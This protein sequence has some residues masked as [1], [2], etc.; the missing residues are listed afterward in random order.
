[1]FLSSSFFMKVVS[2]VL[3]VE[4]EFFLVKKKLKNKW[5]NIMFMV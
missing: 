3:N 5:H 4:F 2:P 1:M